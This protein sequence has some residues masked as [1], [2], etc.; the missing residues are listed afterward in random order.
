MASNRIAVF[1]GPGQVSFARSQC[2]SLAAAKSWCGF[3]PA[4]CAR[5]S[6][7]CGRAPRTTTPSPPDTKRQASSP[8]STPRGCWAFRSASG[9]RSHFSTAA[10]SAK[11]AGAATRT[12]VPARCRGRKPNVFRRIGGLAD[13]AVVPAWKLFPV[14]DDGSFDEMALCEPVACAIHSINMANLRFGDDVLVIGCGTM[15]YL[16][17]AL[18]LLRGVRVFISDSDPQKR[19]AGARSRRECRL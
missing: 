2:P 13:Y 15:G 9:S 3:R 12:S 17:L 6:S 5:W 11:H 10:C 4:P 1:T 19:R 14:S 8:R 16:H 7:G 18:A